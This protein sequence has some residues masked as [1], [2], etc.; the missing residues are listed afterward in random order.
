MKFDNSR[1]I[2]NPSFQAIP[3]SD[4]PLVNSYTLTKNGGAYRGLIKLFGGPKHFLKYSFHSLLNPRLRLGF[5]KLFII[6]R[7]LRFFSP[8]ASV[9]SQSSIDFF[10]L[11]WIML[12][13]TVLS[14]YRP[15]NDIVLEREYQFR[16]IFIF[17]YGI[18]I[19][20]FCFLLIPKNLTKRDYEFQM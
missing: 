19:I 3:I 20:L 7:I 8:M 9:L 12:L 11:L 1:A 5:S 18:T 13:L 15:L 6:S 16:K 17:P 14:K 2:D 10:K 4:L